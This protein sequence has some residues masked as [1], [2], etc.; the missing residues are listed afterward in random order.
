[1]EFTTPAE[2]SVNKSAS[3]TAG[4][5]FQSTDR[6][7]ISQPVGQQTVTL[8]YDISATASAD[9]T[10]EINTEVLNQ[11]DT[12]TDSVTTT[13]GDV[14]TGPVE[15]FDADDDGDISLTEVQDAIRAFS[16]GKLDLQGVQQVIAA[17]SR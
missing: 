4:G 8:V 7:V 17:F 1:L 3:T 5:S 11:D 15:R 13:V 10:F 16:N 6:L 9:A 14:E 2:L 12:T